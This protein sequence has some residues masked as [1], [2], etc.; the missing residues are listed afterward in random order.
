M[1]SPVLREAVVQALDYEE[2]VRLEL[3]GFGGRA[4][5][6]FVPPAMPYFT[7]TPPLEYN[8]EKA[9]ALLKEAGYADADSDGILEDPR[10]RELELRLPA[11]Q[12]YVRTAELIRDY[13]GRIGLRVNPQIVDSSTWIAL[14]ES[15]SYDLTISRTTPWGMFM[16]AN[17]A[18]GY[19]DS[20]R[21]G[22]GVLRTV[23]DP[24]FHALCDAVLSSKRES[25][26]DL[27]ESVQRFYS[28]NLPAAA[29]YWSTILIPHKKTFSGWVVDPLYGLYNIDTFLNLKVDQK[30]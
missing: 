30:Q 13:L 10:G 18:T 6:G 4:N 2:L 23:S 5:R 17:W 29:L 8:P 16:H 19:F 15:F 7:E 26:R 28:Q 11:R 25:M 9:R 22:E 24:A 14:K 20:R 3:L 12:R 27:A 1:S 21:T